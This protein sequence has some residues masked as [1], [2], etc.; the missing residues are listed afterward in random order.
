MAITKRHIIK[1]SG[2]EVG[3]IGDDGTYLCLVNAAGVAVF[4]PALFAPRFLYATIGDGAGTGGAATAEVSI[5]L[6]DNAGTAAA[7]SV[8]LH[9]G[10]Y[11]DAYGAAVATN[12]NIDATPVAG[13]HIKEVTA[14]GK[15][16]IFRTTTAGLLTLTINDASDESVYI[17]VKMAPRSR[18][19]DCSDIGTVTFS[20]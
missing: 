5:Q 20:A 17:L 19:I 18:A 6:Y 15:E 12:A 14:T 16:R 8:V 11:Q 9:V 13:T 10:V 1:S 3:S 2:A 7:E 4:T